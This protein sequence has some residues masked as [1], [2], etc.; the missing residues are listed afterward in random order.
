[1]SCIFF[2]GFPGFLGSQ[3]LPRVL[4]RISGDAVCL[5]QPKFAE[6]ARRRAA[7]LEAHH[8]ELAG[9]IRLVEGDITQPHLGLRDT[10][11][12]GKVREVFHLAAVYDLAVGLEAG[13]RINVAGTRNVLDFA[14]R[15]PHLERVHYVSTCYVSGR[16]AGVF[17]E[18]DLIVGQSFANFYEETKYLGELEVQAR[19]WERQLPATI[20][21]PSIVVGDS[22][23]GAT[24]KFDGPYF[25][26]QWLL[27][28]PAAAAVIPMVGVPGRHRVNVVPSDFVVRAIDHFSARPDTLFGVYHLADP[29]PLTVA[30]MIGVLGRVTGRRI[31]PVPVPLA[32]AKLAIER[33]PGVSRLMRIP[34]Q[35][36]DYFA[37]PTTY[38]T[39]AT[40]AALRGTGIQVPPFASYA[41]RLVSFVRRHPETGSAA[42]A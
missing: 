34:S 4:S 23:S 14:E 26:I 16:H 25:V 38:S 40:E 18:D 17:R 31:L 6:L 41:G 39:A 2:T 27:R 13:M 10:K 36:V 3:L 35:A 9:R 21:R 8:P 30:E 24:Q 1:M 29:A 12:L 42:M 11:W 28:Q 19:M 7:A 37:H 5:V 32:A 33:V 22:V 20:Y 15:C